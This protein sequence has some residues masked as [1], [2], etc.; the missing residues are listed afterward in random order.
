MKRLFFVPV[1]ATVLFLA[2]C[3]GGNESSDTSATSDT[4]TE[5]T[6][7]AAAADAPGADIPGIDTVNVTDNI[8]IDGGDD[9]KF[10]RTLFKI[11][12]AG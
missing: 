9:M 5:A 2:S 4:S 6:T 10:D 3:G 1:M 11:K 7:P 8:K 12:A